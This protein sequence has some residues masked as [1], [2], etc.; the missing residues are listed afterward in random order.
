MRSFTAWPCCPKEP[1]LGWTLRVSYDSSPH[2]LEVARQELGA[3]RPT[4]T[5]R[6]ARFE[7][8]KL[9]LRFERGTPYLWTWT[10]WDRLKIASGFWGKAAKEGVSLLAKCHK[11]P[12]E[13]RKGQPTQPNKPYEGLF[14]AIGP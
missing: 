9:L 4:N 5:L 8:G 3:G 2:D 11:T 7:N 10:L 14:E 6:E 1:S 12:L 13:P